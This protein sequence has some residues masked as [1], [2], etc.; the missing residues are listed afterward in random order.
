[1]NKW[2]Q[3]A[4]YGNEGSFLKKKSDI[5]RVREED[6]DRKRKRKYSEIARVHTGFNRMCVRAGTK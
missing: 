1:M 4:M 2:E 5:Y 6:D 3:K